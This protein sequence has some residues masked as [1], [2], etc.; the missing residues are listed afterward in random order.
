MNDNWRS[1]ARHRVDDCCAVVVDGA[2]VAVVRGG[3]DFVLAATGPALGVLLPEPPQAASTNA[4]A[5]A[6]RIA[7]TLRLSPITRSH[8]PPMPASRMPLPRPR[9]RRTRTGPGRPSRCCPPPAPWS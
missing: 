1:E 5:N 7:F 3:V 2:D 9:P 6:T 4:A 8:P